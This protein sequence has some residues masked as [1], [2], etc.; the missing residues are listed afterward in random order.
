MRDQA[1]VAERIMLHIVLCHS[2]TA[3]E[4]LAHD[5]VFGEVRKDGCLV[6]EN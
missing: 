1:D 3:D 5:G 2:S 4:E 6:E